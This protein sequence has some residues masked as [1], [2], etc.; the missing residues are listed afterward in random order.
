M[1]LPTHDILLQRFASALGRLAGVRRARAAQLGPCAPIGGAAPC[2]GLSPELDAELGRLG[3]AGAWHALPRGLGQRLGLEA[4]CPGL[5]AGLPGLGWA[6]VELEPGA[7]GV[8]AAMVAI[9]EAWAH[10]WDC[11]RAL[12][13]QGQGL[14][15]AATRRSSRIRG[16]MDQ[17]VV[18]IYRSDVAGRLSVANAALARLLGYPSVQAL[19]EHP[20]PALEFY[21]EPGRRAAFLERLQYQDELQD[22]ESQV[23]R[24]DGSLLW[25]SESAR[26]VRDAKGRLRWVE[27]MVMDVSRRRLAEEQAVQATLNDPL[28]GLPGRGLL[29]DRL[30]QALRRCRREATLGFAVLIV[31]L[32]RLSVVNQSL[33][34]A[35]GDA[36]LLEASRRLAGLLR[37]ADTVGRL[38]GDEFV[39][40]LEGV[41]QPEA[42]V[43]V[44]DRVQAAL[45]R[46]M[47]LEGGELAMSACLGVAL[48]GPSHASA[49]HLL[50]DAAAALLRAKAAGPC[51]C[52]VFDPSMQVAAAQRLAVE[53][54]LRRAV[55]RG[56]IRAVFQPIV[57]LPSAA[58]A[59][60]E[61]LARWQHPSLGPV[62]PDEFIAVAEETGQIERLGAQMLEL[63]CAR[64]AEWGQEGSPA[65]VSVNLSPRQLRSDELLPQVREALARHQLDPTRLKLELTESLLL[66]DPGRGGRILDAL[67]GLGCP[68]WLDDF[69]T[70]YS[71]LG[72]LTQFPFQGVKLD[73]SL[74]RDLA[75][76]ERARQLLE[77]VLTLARRLKLQVV[78]EGV[79]DA[80]QASL[81]SQ[82]GCDLGQGYLWAKPLEAADALRHLRHE[83]LPAAPI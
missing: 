56:E 80:R 16:L 18:G 46:P 83:R 33:G 37:P 51:A 53:H 36:V 6:L 11:A 43:A 30:S 54:G 81:L 64:A 35:A 7:S 2:L 66:Q 49:E 61:A 40:V 68:L 55:E 76:S 21:A 42:A 57:A 20:G 67:A 78:A 24:Q 82:L 60:F 71:S 47:A 19:L 13:A 77:G 9:L 15:L 12:Q 10:A 1:T 65:F 73:R 38:G 17:A 75:S 50:R 41:Q 14:R 32:D 3:A 52:E 70:G 23:R 8:A 39:L 48:G 31:D 44:A 28:T 25:V 26:A 4:G 58:L 63:A 5:A 29:L 22:F 59:G 79:E 34:H 27:G 74:V 69:G 72:M 45:A 62:A